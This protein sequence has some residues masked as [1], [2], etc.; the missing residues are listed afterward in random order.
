VVAFALAALR[1][2]AEAAAG[3]V[4]VKGEHFTSLVLPFFVD[5]FN[6]FSSSVTVAVAHETRSMISDSQL[7]SDSCLVVSL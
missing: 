2:V 3:H 7:A 6:S 4:L 5:F 1:L